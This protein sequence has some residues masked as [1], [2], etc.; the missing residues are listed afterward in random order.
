MEVPPAILT[1]TDRFIQSSRFSTNTDA[2]LGAK[3]VRVIINARATLDV[4]SLDKPP[5]SVLG[6]PQGHESPDVD[7]YSLCLSF[8]R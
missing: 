3:A 1:S 8:Y 4:H 6:E 2:Q 7:T 5:R